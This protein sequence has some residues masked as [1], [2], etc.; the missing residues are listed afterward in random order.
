[1][2]FTHGSNIHFAPG[3]YDPSSARGQQILG[4]EL[5]H[6]VQQ[7]TGRVRNPFGT[8][9]AVVQ[10]PALEAEAEQTS[11]RIGSS[12][13]APA[14]VAQRSSI[15][16]VI[17]TPTLGVDV[18]TN[19]Y[20]ACGCFCYERKWKVTNANKAGIIV[21]RV[22]RV[23]HVSEVNSNKEMSGKEIDD[24]V[25][26]KNNV[27]HATVTTYWECWEVDS[28]GKV[29]ET[30]IDTFQLGAI[31]KAK[32]HGTQFDTTKGSY[33]IKGEASFY[34]T[35]QSPDKFGFKR[36]SVSVAGEL[37]GSLTLPIN[38]PSAT[39]GPVK[40]TVDVRWDSSDKKTKDSTVKVS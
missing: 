16:V 17:G 12:R 23:F 9:L 25:T 7:R 6:V 20:G 40:C 3:Q 5:A 32:N 30:G 28:S 4:H 1:L 21:Q 27:P 15:L 36:D 26:T 24:Y 14:R 19:D 34:E 31:I 29:S 33:Q 37:W 39:S 35:N 11:R 38:L 18:K 13:P 10:D 22:D 8:G 2:A